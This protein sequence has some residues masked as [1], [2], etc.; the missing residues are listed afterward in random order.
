MVRI[1]LSGCNG[2]MGQA[3][4][5]VSRTQDNCEIVAGIDINA[6]KLG[7][8]PVYSDFMEFPGRAGVIVDFS[9]PAC[10]SSL[11][12]YAVKN[13]MPVV[14]ATTGHTAQQEEMIEKASLKIPIFRS[15]NMSLG[16]SLITELAKKA[17]KVLGSA[18]DIEIIEK[19][20]N[21]KVDAPSGTAL[22]L[23]KAI[24]SELD[25]PVQPVYD[26]HGEKKRRDKNEIGIHSIRGGT[27]V[28][29]HEILFAGYDEVIEIKHS[30]LSRE[31]F[32][33]GA[34][35]AAAFLQD[36]RRPGMYDMNSVVADQ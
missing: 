33:S 3:I 25:E 1:L 10:L 18:Y 35:K 29:E 9:S 6:V 23:F 14:I 5:R 28:G 19:H 2:R 21:T 11:L 12:S 20:H 24:S 15:A 8:Y 34:L 32:V 16:V 36:C 17:V 7:D 13:S 30:A 26:R 22:M 4:S 31:V 27:I